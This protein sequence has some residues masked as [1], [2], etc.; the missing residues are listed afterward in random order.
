[1]GKED[2][3]GEEADQE[4]GEGG[5]K[6]QSRT[7][8]RLGH[9]S[10]GDGVTVIAGSELPAGNSSKRKARH[11]GFAPP[12]EPKPLRTRL[13]PGTK[14]ESPQDGTELRLD[15]YVFLLPILVERNAIAS[16]LSHWSMATLILIPEAHAFMS[17]DSAEGRSTSYLMLTMTQVVTESKP[18][19][20][21][22]TNNSGTILIRF[23]SQTSLDGWMNLF[24]E[25]D[26]IA[27]SP[28]H[29]A[30]ATSTFPSREPVMKIY[31]TGRSPGLESANLMASLL[32]EDGRDIDHLN[33]TCGPAAVRERVLQQESL[34]KSSATPGSDDSASATF[35]MPNSIS[36][37][38]A[39]LLQTP[40]PI[41]QYTHPTTATAHKNS[42]FSKMETPRTMRT[43][44]CM[45][46]N[47]ELEA[48]VA[49]EVLLHGM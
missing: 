18:T 41:P 16:L 42:N 43:R 31:S 1:M 11:V 38:D 9:G 14:A 34:P 23:P 39:L 13:Q 8:P 32:A 17:V 36:Q 37:S 7:P 21:A 35:I 25:D 12:S 44:T 2:L 33:N 27:L 45:T 29:P 10:C 47:L 46:R 26:L 22:T 3:Q 5:E 49:E 19:V 4:A 40:V 48:V 28:S 6:T 15:S 30:P 24:S 20:R